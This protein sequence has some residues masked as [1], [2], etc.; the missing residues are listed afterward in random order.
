VDQY[1]EIKKVRNAQSNLE[2]KELVLGRLK[3]NN[4][5]LYQYCSIDENYDPYIR[6]KPDGNHN[7]SF[8]NVLDG[9]YYAAR[10]S[11][12]NDPFDCMM[13]VSSRS[14]LSDIMKSY[15]NLKY[16]N[17]PVDKKRLKKSFRIKSI[18]LKEFKK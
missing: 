10:P 17:S 18:D 16:I 8:R 1:E 4:Y 11:E 14:L 3:D 2:I 13:G 9:I 12:F 7:Y 5:K 6:L 15:L